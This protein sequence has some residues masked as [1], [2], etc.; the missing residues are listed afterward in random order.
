MKLVVSRGFD[1]PAY[2]VPLY[3]GTNASWTL[4]TGPY[5]GLYTGPYTGHC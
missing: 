4:D 2:S 1:V 5:T 3:T